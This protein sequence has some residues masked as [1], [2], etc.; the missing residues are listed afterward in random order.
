MSAMKSNEK[1][2]KEGFQNAPYSKKA[3]QGFNTNSCKPSGTTQ[4]D[5]RAVSDSPTSSSIKAACSLIL[6][7]SLE[8]AS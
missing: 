7:L 8:P 3:F 5:I 2:S 6:D 4:A 1:A